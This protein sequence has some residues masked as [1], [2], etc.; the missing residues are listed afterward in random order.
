MHVY[1]S[2]WITYNLRHMSQSHSSKEEEE[3]A[4]CTTDV[5]EEEDDDVPAPSKRGKY[6]CIIN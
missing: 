4:A 3:H 6:N 2:Y 5:E 1:I